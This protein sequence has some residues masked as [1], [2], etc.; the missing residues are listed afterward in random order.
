MFFFFFF[1]TTKLVQSFSLGHGLTPK[2]LDSENFKFKS[3]NRKHLG[4]KISYFW[5]ILTSFL[6]ETRCTAISHPNPY[7]LELSG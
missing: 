6:D 5:L 7:K 1:F 2:D 3:R 4:K